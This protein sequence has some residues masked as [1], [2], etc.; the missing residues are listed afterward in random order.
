LLIFA[1]AV[2]MLRN[3]FSHRQLMLTVRDSLK[4]RSRRTSFLI[5]THMT[6]M[7]FFFLSYL[8]VIFLFINQIDIVSNL[9]IGLIFFFGGIFVYIGI[10]IQQQA[11][12]S[13]K[14]SNQDLKDYSV[15]LEQEQEKLISLNEDLKN[16]ISRRMKAQESEQL[17]SD[18]LSQVSHELRTPLTS[19]FGFTKLMQKDLDAIWEIEGMQAQTVRKRERLEKNLSIVCSECSRLTRLINN[20]L[21]LARIESGQMTWDDVPVSLDDIVGSSVT[22]VEGLFVENSSVSLKV[23]IPRELPALRVDLDLVTQVFVNLISNSVKFTKSG[24]IAVTVTRELHY[25]QVSVCDQG[26][27]MTEENLSRIFDK[28]FI[29][30]KGDTLSST[31]LG[32][33]LGLP[34]CKQIVEHYGGKIWAESEFGVGSCFYVTLPDSLFV[35]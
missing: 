35:E 1:G 12:S 31:K 8:G 33:G 15:R 5:R 32:T 23:D 16:E 10:I 24:E 19:I 13:L 17:K 3:I 28:Y 21:D 18:F 25:I 4:A 29:A 11:F 26:V 27:G 9:F 7:V 2:L 22:A 34:I 6:F 14:A 30:R 20:V